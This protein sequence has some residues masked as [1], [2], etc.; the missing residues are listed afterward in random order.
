MP[1]AVPATAVREAGDHQDPWGQMACAFRS[2]R[3]TVQM[4]GMRW[5]HNHFHRKRL[6]PFTFFGAP[7]WQDA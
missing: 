3:L 1:I 6:C 7:Y 4:A 5:I 2:L